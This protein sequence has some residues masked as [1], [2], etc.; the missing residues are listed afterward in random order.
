LNGNPGIKFFDFN[1]A[2]GAPPANSASN[3]FVNVTTTDQIAA[4]TAPTPPAT[5][6]S[7]DNTNALAIAQLMNKQIPFSSGSATI[8]SYFNTLVSNIGLDVQSAKT[9]VAQDDAFAKQLTTLRES[10]SGVSLDE[11]LTN[12]VKYQRSYQASA[13]LITTAT[14]M[15]DTIIG[16][17]R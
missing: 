1:P 4:T 15:M 14:D 9:T 17:V 7:G 6:A 5:F 3:I 2:L 11:E 12:L 8:G 13:K 16:M 10:N